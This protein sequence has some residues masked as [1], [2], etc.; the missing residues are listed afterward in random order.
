M[1]NIYSLMAEQLETVG[2]DAIHLRFGLLQDALNHAPGD[3]LALRQLARLFPAAD[4]EE[5]TISSAAL[6]NALADGNG[7]SV[8][9]L[10]LATYNENQG[11]LSPAQ[12]HMQQ[13][14]R[15]TP[16]MPEVVNNLAVTLANLDPP[17][18]SPALDIVTSALRVQPHDARIRNTR[19]QILADQ[20]HWEQALPD[21]E[22]ALAV[23]TG[24]RELHETLSQAYEQLGDTDRARLHR[25]R[26]GL[27]A[28]QLQK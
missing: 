9:H 26:A 12:F 17:R 14:Y 2:S 6:H 7:T 20:G 18:R 23:M 19:G 28:G 22:S 27:A 16:R 24:N 1:A 25:E 4:G 11:N 5:S 13:A 8:V 15:S 3:A 10:I 21:L